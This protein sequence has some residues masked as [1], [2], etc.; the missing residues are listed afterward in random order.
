MW[1]W[2]L[3]ERKEPAEKAEGKGLKTDR[4]I[5]ILEEAEVG[6]VDVAW[7]AMDR[8]RVNTFIDVGQSADGREGMYL[9]GC[10]AGGEEGHPAGLSHSLLR[11]R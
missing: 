4:W 7:L 8:W 11:A 5:N 3:I 1:I 10:C 2:L 9:H 6:E